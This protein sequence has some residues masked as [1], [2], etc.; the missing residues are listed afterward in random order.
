MLFRSSSRH[1]AEVLA[2]D[3]ELSKFIQS[4]PPFYSL[5]PDTSLDE[6][7][8]YIPAHRY[9]L[10]TEILFVR[11][12]LHRPYLLRRL[13]SDK[14][15]R[16]RNICFECAMQDFRIRRRFLNTGA[17]KDVRDP[18]TSA[19]RE[20]QAA[21]I[22]G[23]YLVLH[24]KGKDAETM[25]QI[26]EGF[27][28]D[29]DLDQD[30]TTKR[31]LKI[32]QFLRAKGQLSAK[33]SPRPDDAQIPLTSSPQSVHERPHTDAHLL[34]QLSSPRGFPLNGPQVAG[35]QFANGAGGSAIPSPSTPQYPTPPYGASSTHPAVHNIL[36][37]D[38]QSQSA[39][40]SPSNEDETAAQSLLDQWCNVFTGAPTLEGMSG[41]QGMPWSTPGV[42]WQGQ[43][44]MSSGVSPVVGTAGNPAPP[45]SDS[46]DWNY[47]ESL[48]NQIRS[49][50]VA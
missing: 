2:L 22:A 48:I 23:I 24:P 8:Y 16:S 28:A 25:H 44:T 6:T 35:P 9:L 41:T 45:D 3:D 18:V 7:H 17:I 4:L 50:P 19:Y 43:G 36:R 37:S 15:L 27:I 5:D 42:D 33:G 39:A 26:V 12:T 34:L 49:G 31:E 1:Y 29:H 10:V 32:I 46:L 30:N 11:V 20:F 47:W 13:G 21:M 40:G 14:Y 38:S